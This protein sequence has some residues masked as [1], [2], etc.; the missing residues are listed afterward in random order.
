MRKTNIAMSKPVH[1]L[2]YKFLIYIYSRSMNLGMTVS[3]LQL[4][5]TQQKE[6]F[7]SRFFKRWKK[8]DLLLFEV[9]R[10]LLMV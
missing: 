4:Y 9:G 5:H 3:V 2:V 1:I 10:S 6:R 7:L 8:K